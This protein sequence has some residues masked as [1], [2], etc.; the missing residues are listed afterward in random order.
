[1]SNVLMLSAI[2]MLV[3]L[4]GSGIYRR[5]RRFH[6]LFR[7]EPGNQYRYLCPAGNHWY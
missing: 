4:K 3:L 2:V 6:G 1:M 5:P 7:D